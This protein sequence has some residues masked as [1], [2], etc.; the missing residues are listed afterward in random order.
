MNKSLY[1]MGALG[2]CIGILS[3][4]VRC[5]HRTIVDCQVKKVLSEAN[6]QTLEAGIDKG[7]SETKAAASKAREKEKEL[8]KAARKRATHPMKA[9]EGKHYIWL[10]TILESVQ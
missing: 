3:L 6:T 5:Q 8:K 10:Q 7:N 9:P 1:I 4:V 2:L